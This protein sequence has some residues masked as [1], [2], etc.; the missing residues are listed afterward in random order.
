MQTD[1]QR[2]KLIEK[3]VK[4]LNKDTYIFLNEIQFLSE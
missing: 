1:V 4:T 3:L 2:N